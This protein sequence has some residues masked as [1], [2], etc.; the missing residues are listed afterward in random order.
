MCT[1]GGSARNVGKSVNMV[2]SLTV[3]KTILQQHR[4]KSILVNEKIL[5]IANLM[6][7]LCFKTVKNATTTDYIRKGKQH[8]F[9]LWTLGQ[10]LVLIRSLGQVYEVDTKEKRTPN[11]YNISLEFSCTL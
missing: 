5:L 7:C 11:L 6:S 1:D 2:I 3:A 8:Q 10:D 9:Q 4:L